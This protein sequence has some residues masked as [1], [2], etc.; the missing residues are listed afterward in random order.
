MKSFS[1]LFI[2]MKNKPRE[3]EK[4][5]NRLSF[6]LS[7]RISTIFQY[8]PNNVKIIFHSII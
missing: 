2:W 1:A 8:Y 3:I 5:K 4:K 7:S 6:L